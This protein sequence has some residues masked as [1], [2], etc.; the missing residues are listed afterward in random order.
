MLG[1]VELVRDEESRNRA[2]VELD[3]RR[4]ADRSAADDQGK[5]FSADRHYRAVGC[6]R[7]RARNSPP[8]RRPS[9]SMPW[10]TPFDICHS[11]GTSSEASP[12]VAWNSDSGGM[13]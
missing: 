13:S 9:W 6:A 7:R 11:T 12:L 1:G 2:P 10:P 5:G 3:R 4:E 8:W